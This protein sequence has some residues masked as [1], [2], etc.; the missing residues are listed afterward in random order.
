[1]ESNEI[2]IRMLNKLNEHYLAWEIL[3][4]KEQFNIS[5]LTN[6]YTQSI[7]FRTTKGT[8]TIKMIILTVN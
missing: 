7:G 6:L 8:N 5:C 3:N 2:Q 4:P 1:M